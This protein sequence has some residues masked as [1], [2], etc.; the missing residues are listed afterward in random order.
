M[1]RFLGWTSFILSSDA[2]EA[3]LQRVLQ[4]EGKRV[5][6]DHTV[7]VSALDDLLI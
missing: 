5:E 3:D 7:G 2:R 6:D 4:I 1:Y